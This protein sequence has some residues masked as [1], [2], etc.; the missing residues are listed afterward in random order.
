MNNAANHTA[1]NRRPADATAAANQPGARAAVTAYLEAAA[2]PGNAPEGG[3]AA[4]GPAPWGVVLLA[5]GSQRGASRME[6]SCAWQEEIIPDWCRHCPSTPAGLQDAAARL[7]AELG[8]SRPQVVLSCL[9]FLEPFPPQAVK[10]LEG[11]GL[12]QVVVMPFLLGNGKH[13]TLELDE[14]L[15]DLR[16]QTPA[17]ELH[18]AEGLGCDPGLAA[19]VADRV[20]EVHQPPADGGAPA[21]PLPG[22]RRGILLVKAGT[23]TEYDDCLW[24]E[25]LGQLVE[26]RLGDGYAVAVAQSH[27]GDP[28]MDYA[29]AR[30][31]GERQ[32]ASITCVPYLFFPG[33][34]LRR[35]VLGGL[36]QIGRQYPSIPLSVTPPL[37]VD[38]RV[39]AVT[40]SRIRQVW[41][42]Q[43]PT[44]QA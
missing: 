18:L 19:L 17:V 10:L 8:L 14:T 41:Q 22:G 30:L 12:R 3:G 11:R 27:Y 7:Q 31:V 15:D 4:T 6:C 42:A 29:A 43:N 13:A 24:L 9:E 26:E 32:V 39:V 33:L 1:A 37:G 34:I 25:E 21:A 40:A 2:V 20:R 38:D 36:E 28:T 5:H 35:N 23:K 16:A 44:P